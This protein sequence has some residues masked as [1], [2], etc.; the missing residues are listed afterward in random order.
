MH[1]TLS[2]SATVAVRAI[3]HNHQ[4]LSISLLMICISLVA[5]RIYYLHPPNSSE[6]DDRVMPTTAPTGSKGDYLAMISD[7]ID[8][9][10]A[11][12]ILSCF[13]CLNCGN[14]VNME[15]CY[16]VVIQQNRRTH[17]RTSIVKNQHSPTH[18]SGAATKTSVLK[19]GITI[20]LGMDIVLHS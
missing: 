18:L 13:T 12:H 4:H 2:E 1:R 16:V 19:L 5:G 3:S 14:T 11:S 6:I 7:Q 15:L 17:L 8:A 20:L 9:T 10:T